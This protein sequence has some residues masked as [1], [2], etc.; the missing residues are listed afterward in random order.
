MGKLG[1]MS[2]KILGKLGKANYRMLELGELGEMSFQMLELGELCEMSF[3][4]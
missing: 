4:M 2:F 3:K 1:I